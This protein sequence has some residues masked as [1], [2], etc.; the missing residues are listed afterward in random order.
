MFIT[1]ASDDDPSGI[2]TYS[3]VGTQFGF[4]I[5]LMILFLYPLMTPTKE[6]RIK[7]G[8]VTGNGLAEIIKRRYSRKAV[9]PIASLL[10]VANTIN[11][12]AMTAPVWLSLS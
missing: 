8:L 11:I 2:V 1:G 6:I 12:G 3:Q 9:Y 5:L 4:E 10:L 7:I